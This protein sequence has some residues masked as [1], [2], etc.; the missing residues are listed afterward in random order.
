MELN[1]VVT[2]ATVPA[3]L[4]LVTVA[5][6]LGLPSKLATVAAIVFGITLAVA[7]YLF[8]SEGLYQAVSEGLILALGAAGLYDLRKGYTGTRYVTSGADLG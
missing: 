7:D 2:L 5:K 3:I 8:A 4:A 1:A 6:D